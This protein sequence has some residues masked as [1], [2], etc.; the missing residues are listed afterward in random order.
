MLE[1]INPSKSFENIKAVDDLSFSVSVGELFAFLGENG[2][3]KSTTIGIICRRIAKG[4]G[5]VFVGGVD[6][7]SPSR[8]VPR[9]LGVVFQSSVLDAP[10]TVY[11]NLES[12]GA[13]AKL[14]TVNVSAD[15]INAFRDALD[16]N[17]YFF[18]GCV[19]TSV[20]YAVMIASAAAL[21]LV[22]VAINAAE[23]RKI[24]TKQR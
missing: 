15:D 20:M 9:S 2:E 7:D 6:I 10:L 21:T 5:K 19:S 18:D 13:L 11:D 8:E 23:S 17:V 22:F 16:C 3:G 24:H 4:S 14:E 12:R 1:I